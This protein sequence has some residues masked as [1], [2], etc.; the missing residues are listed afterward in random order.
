MSFVQ[1]YDFNCQ[2]HEINY[3]PLSPI[4]EALTVQKIAEATNILRMKKR[5]HIRTFL[6]MWFSRFFILRKFR[7]GSNSNKMVVFSS[8][9]RRF[10]HC[11]RRALSLLPLLFPITYSGPFHTQGVKNAA[12]VESIAGVCASARLPTVHT[13][14]CGWQGRRSL[15]GRPPSWEQALSPEYETKLRGD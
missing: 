8:G 14:S 6:E 7:L 13:V 1:I 9:E 11:R 10:W 2:W 15:L 3:Q 4:S 5:G 12:I